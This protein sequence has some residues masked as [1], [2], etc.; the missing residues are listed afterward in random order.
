LGLAAVVWLLVRKFSGL[1][2]APRRISVVPISPP[3][4]RL[5]ERFE[6]FS[7]DLEELDFDEIGAYE[8]QEIR[9][10]KLLAFTQTHTKVCAVIYDHPLS[11]C[12]VDMYSEN[13]E[14]QSLTVSN[15]PTGT[16]LEHPP[17]H[18]KIVDRS[19]TVREMYERLLAERPQAPHKPVF[20]SNFVE[21]YKTA[22]AREMS[23][24]AHRAEAAAEEMRR[25]EQTAG[26]P[27]DA[28]VRRTAE[29]LR[30]QY[31]D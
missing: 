26:D 30:G 29:R 20:Y 17:G 2:E 18:E 1:V 13:S 3:R 24:R 27:S 14:G 16:E 31:A 19:L 4:G 11:G 6:R 5:K 23:W 28:D 10:L 9:G 21:N 12:F 22:Y 7:R 8:V 25:T 15:G